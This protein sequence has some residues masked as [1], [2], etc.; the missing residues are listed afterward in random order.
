M[1]KICQKGQLAEWPTINLKETLKKF[2]KESD[3]VG[4]ELDLN[5]VED[6]TESQE[7]RLQL[8]AFLPKIRLL[9][10]ELWLE[11]RR[12]DKGAT[13]G[14]VFVRA[15]SQKD[16]GIRC[17]QYIFVYTRQLTVVSPFWWV[18]FPLLLAWIPGSLSAFFPLVIVCLLLHASDTTKKLRLRITT[19][20]PI[21]WFIWMLDAWFSPLPIFALSLLAA[22]SG[23]YFCYSIMTETSISHKMD[24][25]PVFVWIKKK[26]DEW[27]LESAV[28][29]IWHYLASKET[30]D[31]L[32]KSY[33]ARIQF[34]GFVE[35]KK[36]L[37]LAMDNPWHSLYKR[38]RKIWFRLVMIAGSI[39]AVFILLS[40]IY[41]FPESWY[42][43]HPR[44]AHT[45]IFFLLLVNYIALWL[46]SEGLFIKKEKE[47]V[48]GAEDLLRNNVLD[49]VDKEEEIKKLWNTAEFMPLC[50]ENLK[51][52]WNMVPE[53]IDTEVGRFGRAVIR[54][55]DRVHRRPDE[56]KKARFIVISKLQDPFTNDWDTF[57]DS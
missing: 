45:D 29:D 8:L 42:I 34:G 26:N 7:A 43:L 55:S 3:S 14:G 6:I 2:N 32:T 20:L 28:W 36:R 1:T 38:P 5:K 39:I 53:D 15:L 50:E 19:G 18:L 56:V 27:V 24:Y 33:W 9:G 13:W 51:F 30:L 52:L 11:R 10:P 47:V 44:N 25:I 4:T 21:F 23:L 37:R 46:R 22:G 49:Q 40:D 16:T 48:E 54:I 31:Q 35:K 57:L 12:K 17:L 41:L